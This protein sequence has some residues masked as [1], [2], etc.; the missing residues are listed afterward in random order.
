VRVDLATEGQTIDHPLSI[1]C[2]DASH[3]VVYEKP[4]QIH[5]SA[6]HDSAEAW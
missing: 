1:H 6:P 5:P 2:G 4:A 3:P